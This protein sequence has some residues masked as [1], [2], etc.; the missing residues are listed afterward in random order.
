[1][2]L[3][4]LK[5]CA[6]CK[7]KITPMWYVV[8]FSMAMLKPQAANG[9]MGLMQMLGGS[10]ALAEAMAPEPDCV[11]VMGDKEPA[12]SLESAGGR[13]R[14]R[15]RPADRAQGCVRHGRGGDAGRSAGARTAAGGGEGSGSREGKTEEVM[16]MEL[17]QDDVF[18]VPQPIRRVCQY[19]GCRTVL[20]QANNSELCYR[21]LE[22]ERQHELARDL[23]RER[24]AERTGERPP[25]KKICLRRGC[26]VRLEMGN[27]SG[28]CRD[29]VVAEE[30]PA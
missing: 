27:T 28:Y 1:M 19:P 12:R 3:S 9:V 2:K 15:R 11:V 13:Y 14:L 10:L 18:F 26:Y 29:H 6:V 8:R 30:F 17:V 5:P 20:A 24:A 16:G 23:M 21:H 7:G 25:K 4:E 22:A